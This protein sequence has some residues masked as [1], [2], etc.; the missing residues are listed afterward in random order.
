MKKAV[1][2]V[3]CIILIAMSFCFQVNAINDEKFVPYVVDFTLSADIDNFT[4]DGETNTRAS[5]L[6]NSYGLNLS[7]TGTTL[8]ITGQ[9]HGSTDV[10]KCGFKDLTIQRR[11]SS[12]YSWE[13]YYEYGNLY[14][15]ATF[16]S[17]NTTLAVESGYQYRISCKHYAKK[18]L[19]MVETIS[20]TS[21]IV[22]V[23]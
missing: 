17:L 19:L 12:S 2:F 10:V 11:K 6:I 8:K 16:A 7:V 4:V 13:D 3:L 18:N 20:N 14:V 9:T 5:G 22:T 1:S 15:D 21:G 23:S